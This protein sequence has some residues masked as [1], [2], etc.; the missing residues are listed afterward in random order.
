MK[1]LEASHVSDPRSNGFS[2]TSPGELVLRPS[3][4][5]SGL[6][7][8]CGCE[9]SWSGITSAKGTTIAVVADRDIPEGDYIAVVTAHLLSA[10]DCER[11]DAAAEA[12]YLADLAGDYPTETLLAID[13]SDDSEHDV[14]W[15]LER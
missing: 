3:I 13:L 4:C 12:R 9:R 14:I 5:D 2:F 1:V 6:A 11:A 10:H 15:A 7:R 8:R